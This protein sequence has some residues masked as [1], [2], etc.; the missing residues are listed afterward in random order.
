[1]LLH[2]GL[3]VVDFG[4]E[5]LFMLL[6]VCFDVGDEVLCQGIDCLCDVGPNIH[7]GVVSFEGLVGSI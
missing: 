1:M 5:F 2:L 4:L 6:A 7:L 3:Q